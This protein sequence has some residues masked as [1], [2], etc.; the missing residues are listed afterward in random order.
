MGPD[1]IRIFFFFGK[2]IPLKIAQNQYCYFEVVYHVYSVC[3][4]IAKVVGYYD[5]SVL[6]MSVM[7]FQRKS[8]DWRELYP[9]FLGIFLIVLTL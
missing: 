5:L 7:G 2:I 6:S 8:L 3:I 4:Y 1:L 9:L